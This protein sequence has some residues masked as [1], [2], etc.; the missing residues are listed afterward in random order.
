M[1]GRG[2][3]GEGRVKG[4]EEGREV[5]RGMVVEGEACAPVPPNPGYAILL[6][7]QVWTPSLQLWA[8]SFQSESPCSYVK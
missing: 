2:K 3:G 8:Y 6:Y 4:Y 1:K 7:I 5:R